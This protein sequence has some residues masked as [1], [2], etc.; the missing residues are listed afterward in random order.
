MPNVCHNTVEVRGKDE[1]VKTF[2]EYMRTNNKY[3]TGEDCAFDFGKILPHPPWFKLYDQMKEKWLNDRGFENDIYYQITIRKLY[4]EA[5]EMAGL[6]HLRGCDIRNLNED[7]AKSLQAV[8]DKVETFS[9]NDLEPSHSSKDAEN[10]W[11]DLVW[12]ISGNWRDSIE[13]QSEGYARYYFATGW[14]YPEDIYKAML[15]MFPHLTFEIT[16]WSFEN[17]DNLIIRKRPEPEPEDR[18]SIRSWDC[19]IGPYKKKYSMEYVEINE[20]I[21]PQHPEWKQATEYLKMDTAAAFHKQ[22]VILPL[23]GKEWYDYESLNRDEIYKYWRKYPVCS[24]E[25]DEYLMKNPVE[26]KNVQLKNSVDEF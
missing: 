13:E 10:E 22:R 15:I 21:D 14:G 17:M 8:K 25:L 23:T 7:E 3:E 19:L 26:G 20:L 2:V 11:E 5:L 4:N 6:G 12:G 1:D 16:G 18:K 9:I 24:R